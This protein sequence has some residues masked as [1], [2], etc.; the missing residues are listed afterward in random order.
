MW[1][2]CG[3]SNAGAQLDRDRVRLMAAEF[4]EDLVR[5]PPGVPGRRSVTGRVVDVAKVGQRV[6]LLVAVAD[7]L[8]RVDGLPIALQGTQVIAELVVEVAEA[9]QAA[10]PGPQVADLPKL[11]TA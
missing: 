11:P 2:P 9:V 1:K 6:R 4:V 7:T 8:V 5:L 10:R 3:R